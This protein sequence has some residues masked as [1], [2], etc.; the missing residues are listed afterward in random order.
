MAWWFDEA[1][2]TQWKQLIESVYAILFPPFCL[3]CGR[4]GEYLCHQCLIFLIEAEPSCLS[5]GRPSFGGQSH[6]SCCSMVRGYVAVWEESALIKKLIKLIGSRSADHVLGFLTKRALSVLL[7]D[8]SRYDFW[9]TWFDQKTL[10]LPIVSEGSGRREKYLSESLLNH[11]IVSTNR[12]NESGQLLSGGKV[13][14]VGPS[15]HN[16]IPKQIESIKQKGPNE[17]WLLLLVGKSC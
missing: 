9:S 4:E 7:S 16:G 3:N 14:L 8:D 13:V 2:K 17:V 5:C 11:L 1:M 12:P 15:W 6:Q 10:I